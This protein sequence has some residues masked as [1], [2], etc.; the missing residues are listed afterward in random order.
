MIKLLIIR[1]DFPIDIL[2]YLLAIWYSILNPPAVN[3]VFIIIPEA[4][5]D[6]IP[7]Y[8]AIKSRLSVSISKYTTRY[9]V[10]FINNG[11]NN[12][13]IV[14]LNVCLN[15][16][17]KKHST[18]KAKETYR[19]NLLSSNPVRYFIIIDNPAL[20]PVTILNFA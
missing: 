19:T 10:I 14:F 1:L 20:P 6:N 2:K 4:N 16:R 11:Y 7:A 3:F 12:V 8:N 17:V 18:N 15:P 5:P 13:P 9:D